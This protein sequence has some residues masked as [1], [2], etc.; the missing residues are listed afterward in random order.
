[1]Y[2]NSIIINK[3]ELIIAHM[4]AILLNTNKLI[5][6][7]T[8]MKNNKINFVTVDKSL[9]K[10]NSKQLLQFHINQ[11]RKYNTN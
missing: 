9:N 10:L 8:L 2:M 7:Y 4:R 11:S 6:K 3:I 1:M 5:N